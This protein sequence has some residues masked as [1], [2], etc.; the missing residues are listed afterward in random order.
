MYQ[1]KQNW[2]KKRTSKIEAATVATIDVSLL[3][4]GNLS[5]P[6][7]PYP[8]SRDSEIIVD[9]IVTPVASASS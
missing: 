2:Q 3:S 5:R 1:R 8:F 4:K 7:V 6:V 9:K